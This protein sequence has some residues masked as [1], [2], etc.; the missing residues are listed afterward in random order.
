MYPNTLPPQAPVG[1]PPEPVTPVPP[2]APPPV[3]EVAKKSS[4]LTTIAFVLLGVAAL[5]VAAYFIG[6]FA[7]NKKVAKETP[8]PIAILSPTPTPDP[9]ANWKTYTSDKYKFSFKYPPTLTIEINEVD[10]SNYVQIIFNK[11]LSDSFTIKASIK[12]PENQPKFLLDTQPIGTE[13]IDSN[14]W[15]VFKLTNNSGL[16]LEKSEVLYSI[17]YPDSIKNLI[18]QILSTFKFLD[19]SSTPSATGK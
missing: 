15:S 9:T 4:P 19:A 18:D 5:A 11:S 10:T 2:I 1:M 14:V 7:A 16:Q 8:T 13:V 6:T 3:P 17:I 12:Y